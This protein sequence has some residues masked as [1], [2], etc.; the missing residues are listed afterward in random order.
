MGS[1][2]GLCTA[3]SS[4]HRLC[5]MLDSAGQCRTLP[6]HSSST[7]V[8]LWCVLEAAALH[9]RLA[10]C[11]SLLPQW[12]V[13]SIIIVG[14][15]CMVI[16]SPQTV[17]GHHKPSKQAERQLVMHAVTEVRALHCCIEPAP[18]MPNVG[19]CR[20]V[21]DTAAAQQQYSSSLVVRAGGRSSTQQACLLWQP[22]ATVAR[23]I[24]NHSWR[25]LHGDPVPSDCGRA[26]QAIQASRA[27]TCDARCDRGHTQSTVDSDKQRPHLAETVCPRQSTH[28]SYTTSYAVCAGGNH[29]ISDLTDT[30]EVYGLT[31]VSQNGC[32]PSLAAERDP[33]KTTATRRN[34]QTPCSVAHKSMAQP[35]L[36]RT[37]PCPPC[38]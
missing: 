36:C 10:Y 38:L 26:P 24:H 17:A 14:V 28:G 29:C 27:S 30:S 15:I 1:W 3:A 7:R 4:Q 35:T 25:H 31:V 11:G 6:Q 33:R 21:P 19:Q 13:T 37:H 23:H 34:W 16:Q 20:T 12:H 8:H 22:V 2:P 5:Q 9:S 18:L 32:H